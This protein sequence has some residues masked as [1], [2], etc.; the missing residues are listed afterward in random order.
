MSLTLFCPSCSLSALQPGSLPVPAEQ[1]MNAQ[2]ALAVLCLSGSKD[3]LAGLS[4]GTPT[5]Q[6]NSYFFQIMY[7]WPSSLFSLTYV[8]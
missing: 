7:V 2:S 5:Q 8:K 3:S 4:S 1:P 6:P